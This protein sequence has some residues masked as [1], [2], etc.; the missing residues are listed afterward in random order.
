MIILLT[1]RACS[2]ELMTQAIS[3]MGRT[4]KQSVQSE[5]SDDNRVIALLK[6]QNELLT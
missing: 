6:R 3:M 5:G 1:N 2:I 4:K